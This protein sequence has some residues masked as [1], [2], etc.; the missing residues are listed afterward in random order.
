ME[1]DALKQ[2]ESVRPCTVKPQDSVLARLSSAQCAALRHVE[3]VVRAEEPAARRLL[4]AILSRADRK[5]D[6]YNEAMECMGCT[7]ASCCTFIQTG[8]GLS[9]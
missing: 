5:I 3:A 6:D 8:S 1:Q 2:P 4:A 7:L 9:L